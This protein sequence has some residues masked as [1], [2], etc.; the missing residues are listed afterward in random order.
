M[1][2]VCMARRREKLDTHDHAA[3]IPGLLE[4]EPAGIRR[5]RLLAILAALEGEKSIAQI[6]K[7][8]GRSQQ[9][10]ST[11]M[12]WFREGGLPGLLERPGQGNGRESDLTPRLRQEL[13]KKVAKGSFRRAEDARQWLG[14]RAKRDFT[15]GVTYKYLKMC[16]AS[17]KVPRPRN[18]KKNEAAAVSFKSTLARKIHALGLPEGRPLRVWVSD[19]A[20]I[21]L[22]PTLRKC[23]VRRGCRAHKNSKTR[24]DWRYVWGA[25]QVGGGG[26]EFLYTDTASTEASLL[27]LRQISERD[28][29]AIHVVVWDG[30]GFHPSGDHPG[31]PDNVRVLKQPPYS[32]ELNAVEKLWDML[33]DALCNRSWKGGIDEMMGAATR[34]LEGF[35]SDGR[36]VLSLVG[37]GWMRSQ[38][39]A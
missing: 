16:G 15:L 31:I 18:E 14:R 13:L 12:R 37:D 25:L 17:L 33:R 21:G 27:F 34:F 6:G 4:K 3:Q 9:S 2:E 36:N 24:Y 20:R 35:W 26:S 10:V 7:D 1:L 29:L 32:P 5:E 28:P 23:W 19:E 11:W 22:H 38:A 30:A 8:L 39:N